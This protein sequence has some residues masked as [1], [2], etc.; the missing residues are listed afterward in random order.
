MKTKN[1]R[2][3]PQNSEKLI[4]PP[5]GIKDSSVKKR[6]K[7]APTLGCGRIAPFCDVRVN[8]CSILLDKEVE[9]QNVTSRRAEKTQLVSNQKNGRI[10]SLT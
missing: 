4:S 5:K 10:P 8:Q 9:D 7:C 6:K 2:F 1:I 3:F